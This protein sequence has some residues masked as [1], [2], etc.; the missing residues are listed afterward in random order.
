MSGPSHVKPTGPAEDVSKT[1]EEDDG[2]PASE[3]GKEEQMSFDETQPSAVLGLVGASY[4]IVLI[5]VLI[6][7]AIYWW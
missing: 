2:V 4:L 7:A 6:A 5:L 1:A 3:R